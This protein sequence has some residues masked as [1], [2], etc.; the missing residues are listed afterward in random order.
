MLKDSVR[1]T[2]SM[3]FFIFIIFIFFIIWLKCQVA[4]WKNLFAV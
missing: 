3:I 1:K 4:N 2:N